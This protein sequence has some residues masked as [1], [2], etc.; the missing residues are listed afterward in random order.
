MNII[1]TFIEK[2]TI[3]DWVT[4]LFGI[5]IF[6]LLCIIII[7]YKNPEMYLK[8][9]SESEELKY[10]REKYIKYLKDKEKDN[11]K[12]AIIEIKE[13]E[14]D[15]KTKIEIKING[16]AKIDEFPENL[17]KHNSYKRI[18]PLLTLSLIMILIF[19]VL[20]C[21]NKINYNQKIG[22]MKKLE[23]EIKKEL[24]NKYKEENK[25]EL[26]EKYHNEIEKLKNEIIRIK[27]EDQNEIEKTKIFFREKNKRNKH[28]M[29]SF[30]E[31]KTQSSP[32]NNKIIKFNN[33]LLKYIN[34]YP[35]D[36]NINELKKL[37]NFLFV[38]K[39]KSIQIKFE[40]IN[41]IGEPDGDNDLFIKIFEG[42]V[43]KFKEPKII[44]DGK[45]NEDGKTVEFP[46]NTYSFFWNPRKQIRFELWDKDPLRNDKYVPPGKNNNIFKIK[47]NSLFGF[48]K[49]KDTSRVLSYK[50]Y[51][52]NLK[53]IIP[54]QYRIDLDKIFID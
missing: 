9:F 7:K 29:K 40:I 37:K 13:K 28:L 24:K 33:K 17:I 3:L 39:N 6:I 18:S 20:I 2:F 38:I 41:A 35:E 30:F 52:I 21:I 27:N 12:E 4:V 14:K 23:N 49:L 1:N 50:K 46:D 42:N 54:K 45:L 34:D 16:S 48:L 22:E 5:L 32:E 36:K 19:F 31:L 47:T 10:E 44:E 25:K 51:R 15:G 53:T 8:N 43:N 26:E 11:N